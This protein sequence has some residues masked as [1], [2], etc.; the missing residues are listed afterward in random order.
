VTFGN[1]SIR[2]GF[3]SRERREKTKHQVY[4]FVARN[5]KNLKVQQKPPQA[6]IEAREVKHCF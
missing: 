1:A 5:E 2:D 4:I 6:G 3:N